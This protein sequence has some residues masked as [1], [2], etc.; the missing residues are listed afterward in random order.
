MEKFP[1]TLIPVM[2]IHYT[3]LEQLVKRA[4]GFEITFANCTR[5]PRDIGIG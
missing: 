4:F 2:E 3:V 5:A 1:A